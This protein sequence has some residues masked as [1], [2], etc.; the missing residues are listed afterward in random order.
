MCHMPLFCWM[1]AT[2]Y[3]M[4]NRTGKWQINS[5]DFPTTLTEMLIHFLHI[6]INMKNKKL[7][8]EFEDNRF[9]LWDREKQSV[10]KLAKLALEELDNNN[11][12][13]SNDH[14][15]KCGID[16]KQTPLHSG[17]LTEICQEDAL[18][19]KSRMYCFV[20]PII[21]EF[22]AA[23][24][25]FYAYAT[26]DISKLRY[27]SSIR[28]NV[29]PHR[30]PLHH[31]LNMAVD[32]ALKSANGHLDLFLRFLLGLSVDSSQEL[33]LGLLPD[34]VRS[35]NSIKEVCQTIHVKFTENLSPERCIN[36][37]HCL[38][39]MKNTTLYKH[40]KDYGMCGR[41]D[42]SP[43]HCSA[44]ASILL[45]SEEPLEEF[46]LRMYKTSEEGCRRLVPVV[47]W[48]KKALLAWCK[49]TDVSCTVVA[50]ALKAR[51]SQLTELDLTCNDLFDPG[52]MQ[53]C[54]GLVSSN[55]TVD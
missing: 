6:Q 40:I 44:L 52:M 15:N 34:K 46:D 8:D 28:F 13:F 18:F 9:K 47:K 38:L 33:L 21:Q 27:L 39:E 54:E 4:L 25:V 32:G 49:L 37:F 42:L 14:L 17:I 7:H 24:Y 48:C 5:S 43:A 51:T 36:L 10:L 12:M 23:L 19:F 30:V 22:L 29:L 45:M 50:S 3:E 26:Q 16:V 53:L 20:H 55:C 31:I 11:F 1:S 2:V 41:T 35:S